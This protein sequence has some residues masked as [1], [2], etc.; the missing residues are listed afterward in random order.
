MVE[1]SRGVF[2]LALIANLRR[3]P[4]L[5]PP[6]PSAMPSPPHTRS[7][8][9]LPRPIQKSSMASLLEQIKEDDSVPSPASRGSAPLKQG[10]RGKAVAAP[11]KQQHAKYRKDSVDIDSLRT[12]ELYQAKQ[13]ERIRVAFK[14]GKRREVL[15][16]STT[17]LAEAATWDVPCNA[18][19]YDGAYGVVRGCT[20][21]VMQCSRIV[22]DGFGR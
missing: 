15:V 13:A 10:L 6:L 19:F 20:P 5:I 7:N 22:R 21:S 3:H 16:K 17:R 1:G 12:R 18:E 2:Q 8:V 11:T 9:T 14:E 4:P